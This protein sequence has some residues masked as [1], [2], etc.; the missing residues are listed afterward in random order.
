MSPSSTLNEQSAREA[1]IWL[2]QLMSE[3]A[4]QEDRDNWQ[5]WY[6]SRPENA[7][8]WR[9]IGE[10]SSGFSLLNGA[11][12]QQSLSRLANPQRRRLLKS[13]AVVGLTGAVGIGAGNG[14]WQPWLADYRTAIGEQKNVTLSDGTQLML[15]TQTA[16]N[17]TS[18]DDGQQ[19][20]LLNG[21][22]M[23]TSPQSAGLLRLRLPQGELTAHNNRFAIR[24]SD[25]QS[26]IAVYRGQLNARPAA[27]SH[28]VTINAGYGLWLNEHG[29][30]ALHRVQ[31][32]PAWLNGL[33]VAD[34]MR[35]ADFL[36]ELTRYRRGYIRYRPE[37]A[38]LRLS[39]VFPLNNTDRIL[40]AL[41]DSLPVQIN[42]LSK[43]FVSVS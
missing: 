1:A 5:R 6:Q 21:E 28:S 43:Y 10:F 7:Q 42:Y 32:E 39:G 2:T 29:Y 13:I 25:T 11:A 22:M 26:D 33:I 9:Q 35:L 15:N 40:D 36:D 34:D 38:N 24:L 17:V 37:V 12:A 18:H 41:P 4:S 14:L 27:D 3:E 20:A 19:V 30:S 31:A 16:V 8:A 23:V